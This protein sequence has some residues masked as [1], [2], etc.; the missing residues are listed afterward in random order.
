MA[1]LP[2]YSEKRKMRIL[3]LCNRVPW[4]PSS[5]GPIATV[6]IIKGFQQLGHNLHLLCLNPKKSF[7]SKEETPDIF[8][9]LDSY[10]A[11]YIDTDIEAF[12]AL[13]NLLF[14]KESYHISRFHSKAFSGKLIYVLQNFTFDI[15]QLEGLHISIYLPLIR[16]Y[17][18]AKIV[19]RAHNVEY[20]IWERLASAEK[21]PLKKWYVSLL[22]ERL[23]K[24]EVEVLNKFDAIVPITNYD[25]ETF[26]EL[27]C[28][29]PIHVSPTGLNLDE[30]Q[31]DK[32]ATEFPSVFHLGALDW[33]PNLQAIEWFL[34]EV[35]PK[36]H[37]QMPNLKFYIAGRHMPNSIKMLQVA[38]VEVVGEVEDAKAF[39]NSKSIMIVPLLSGSGMRIK[40]IEGMALAKTIVSTSIGAEGIAVDH[41]KNILIADDAN[42]FAEAV[43]RCVRDR[44][45]S[46]RLGENARKLIE[47]KYS[48]L[49]LVKA[50]SGFYQ[51]L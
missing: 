22:A 9:D 1:L 6:N 51:R 14:S 12:G 44:S 32:S 46:E 34:A 2:A 45:F 18:K 38:G 19:L 37:A 28:K 29:I 42:S 21:N 40:I 24:Y 48:N 3:L 17:S 30:Y 49:S 33:M 13:Y 31:I 41:E 27:G 23:K 25:A 5:G 16:Q 43:L 11:V 10:R 8:K 4:P 50:L 36:I 7:V 47:E 39:M 15:I 35:W 20:L 26:K